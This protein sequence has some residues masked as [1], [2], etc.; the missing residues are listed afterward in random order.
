MCFLVDTVSQSHKVKGRERCPCC[1]ELSVHES[2][3]DSC[4]VVRVWSQPQKTIV[5]VQVPSHRMVWVRVHSFPLAWVQNTQ[6]PQVF[7]LHGG[8]DSISLSTLSSHCRGPVKWISIQH[9]VLVTVCLLYSA[10]QPLTKLMRIVHIRVSLYTAS[11]PCAHT[12]R[13]KPAS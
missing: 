3:L 5:W 12:Q 8:G 10:P 6:S 11:K 1:R 2:D 7:Q 4:I 9:G 13:H